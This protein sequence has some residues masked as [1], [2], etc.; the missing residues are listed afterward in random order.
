MPG[1]RSASGRDE[2]VQQCDERWF[3]AAGFYRMLQPK[4]FGGYGFDNVTF[5][6]VVYRISAEA[7]QEL[8]GPDGEFRPAPPGRSGR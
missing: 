2:E 1:A 5:F 8:L 7:Q 3:R 4:I 6:E